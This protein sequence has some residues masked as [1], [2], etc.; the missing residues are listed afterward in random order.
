MLKRKVIKVEYT[1]LHRCEVCNKIR[2]RGY[3]VVSLHPGQIPEEYV[4]CFVC[5]KRCGDMY[6]LSKI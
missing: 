5:S 3:D 6:I 2:R 1:G 4:N